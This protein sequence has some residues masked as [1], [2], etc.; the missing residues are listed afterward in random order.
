MACEAMPKLS[1]HCRARVAANSNEKKLSLTFVPFTFC[2]VILVM[3]FPNLQRLRWPW[4]SSEIGLPTHPLKNSMCLKYN[5]GPVRLNA[6]STDCFC[7]FFHPPLLLLFKVLL[8]LRR[9]QPFSSGF[10]F[11]TKTSTQA[12]IYSVHAFEASPA[13]LRILSFFG[14]RMSSFYYRVLPLL[15]PL[16]FRIRWL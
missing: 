12:R 4:K 6:L 11:T 16:V 3:V 1:Y 13:C 5:K 2:P 10:P 14:M 8:S 7:F 15:I 9:G